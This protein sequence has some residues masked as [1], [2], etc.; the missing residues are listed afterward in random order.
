MAKDLTEEVENICKE[1]EAVNN[2]EQDSELANER[3][4]QSL[5]HF[6]QRT[7]LRS[8]RG[9]DVALNMRSVR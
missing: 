9:R 4:D 5:R 8:A 3:P 2:K 1:K 7:P 6:P